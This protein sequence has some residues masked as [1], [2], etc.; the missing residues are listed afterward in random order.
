[1]QAE[2]LRSHPGIQLF[3][4]ARPVEQVRLTDFFGAVMKTETT[5][6]QYP[7]PQ[8]QASVE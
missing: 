8:Q 5:E 2:Q 3:N 7:L 1:L 6:S 4:F